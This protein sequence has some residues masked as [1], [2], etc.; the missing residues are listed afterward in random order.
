MMCDMLEQAN[1]CKIQDEPERLIVFSQDGKGN[2]YRKELQV[3]NSH[4]G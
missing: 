1:G 4:V 2:D 3:Q